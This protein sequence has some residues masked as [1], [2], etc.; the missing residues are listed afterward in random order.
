MFHIS[1]FL[2]HLT[3]L[4]QRLECHA[5]AMIAVINH[6]ANREDAPHF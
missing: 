2:T 3:N 5:Y 4:S 6:V 1:F